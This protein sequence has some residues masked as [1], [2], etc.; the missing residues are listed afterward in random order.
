LLKTRRPWSGD[1]AYP[2]PPA[3]YFAEV[4]LLLA[5]LFGIM[6]RWWHV[7]VEIDTI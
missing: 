6:N 3:R 2:R 7:A 4:R 1:N 5:A